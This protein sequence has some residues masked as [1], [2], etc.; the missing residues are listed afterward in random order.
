MDLSKAF[1]TIKQDLLLAKL[2]A[3]CFL[4]KSLALMCSYLKNRRQ[5]TQIN[6]SFS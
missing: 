6:N 2:K 3:Y 5:R 1:D 4:D